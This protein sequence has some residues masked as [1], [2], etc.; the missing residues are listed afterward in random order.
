[1]PWRFLDAGQLSV[2]SVSSLPASKNHNKSGPK[3]V[4]DQVRGTVGFR[5]EAAFRRVI[6]MR[7]TFVVRD[8]GDMVTTA[9]YQPRWMS[10]RATC[11]P[12]C[13]DANTPRTNKPKK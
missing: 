7:D 9:F 5:R 6:D 10:R 4:L 11:V 8:G 13:G 1:M 2:W 12:I 3:P